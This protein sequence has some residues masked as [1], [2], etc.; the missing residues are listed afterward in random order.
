MIH[1]GN[2]SS[3]A[4]LTEKNQ[5]DRENATTWMPDPAGLPPEPSPFG[6]LRAGERRARMLTTRHH[7]VTPSP[8]AIEITSPRKTAAHHG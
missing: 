2:Q 5:Y 1:S 8:T 4:R 7:T 3:V 6:D